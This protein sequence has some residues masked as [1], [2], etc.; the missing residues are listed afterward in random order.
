MRAF[1][2][3]VTMVLAAA[4]AAAEYDHCY[5]ASPP[6]GVKSSQEMREKTFFLDYGLIPVLYRRMCDL[7]DG[8][9]QSYVQWLVQNP[10]CT[11]T[12]D[13]ARSFMRVL[14][15][16]I[17]EIE[18]FERFREIRTQHPDFIRDLCNI[19]G[20]IPWPIHIPSGKKKE[21][22]QRMYSAKMAEVERRLSEFRKTHPHL[23]K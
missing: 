2:L 10:G 23:A 6:K 18:G 12:S 21:L 7:T 1:A 14:T 22:I 17:D 9:D 5:F 15:A 16:S 13:L 11:P 8:T 3:S 19:V 4:P 20:Q